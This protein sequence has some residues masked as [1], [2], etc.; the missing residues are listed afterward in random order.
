MSKQLPL[1][2][3]CGAAYEVS[4]KVAA[5]TKDIKIFDSAKYGKQNIKVQTDSPTSE[6]DTY[7]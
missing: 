1:N 4:Q 3:A 7:L 6:L 2:E 5:Q